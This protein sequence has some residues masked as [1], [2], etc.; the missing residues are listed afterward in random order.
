MNYTLGI[1]A[2]AEREYSKLP[3]EIQQRLAT[4]INRLPEEPR[5]HGYIKLKGREEYRIRV[6]EYRVAYVVD[7][8]RQH[9]GITKVGH[10]RDFYAERD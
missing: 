6:G 1:K 9:I 7:D 5:P 4:A 2:S 8:R 3:S 10:R